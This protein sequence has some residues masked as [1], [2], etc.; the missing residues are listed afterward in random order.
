[1][2]QEGERTFLAPREQL[3]ANVRVA[4]LQSR[5]HVV[6]FFR[7]PSE[8]AE[9]VNLALEFRSLKHGEEAEIRFTIAMLEGEHEER[10]CRRSTRPVEQFRECH[11]V[12]TVAAHHERRA[13]EH[14]ESQKQSH[15]WQLA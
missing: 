14:D 4:R 2:T 1:M 5:N 9:D 6:E 12:T 3:K 13:D 11:G 15:V 8:Q 10:L 7:A